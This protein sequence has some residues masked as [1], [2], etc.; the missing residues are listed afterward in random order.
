MTTLQRNT[1]SVEHSC[2]GND[3]RDGFHVVGIAADDGSVFWALR[4]VDTAGEQDPSKGK[5]RAVQFCPWCAEEF[6]LG[7]HP[8]SDVADFKPKPW[9]KVVV[10]A[11]EPT[12]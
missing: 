12:A 9:S 2:P 10:P 8:A 6:P 5:L 11:T 7:A 3:I 4:A 1:P